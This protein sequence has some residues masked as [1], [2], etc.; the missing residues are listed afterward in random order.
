MAHTDMTELQDRIREMYIYDATE[1][2]LYNLE[3]LWPAPQLQRLHILRLEYDTKFMPRLE[4]LEF[5]LFLRHTPQAPNLQYLRLRDC[6]L[7]K[8][9]CPLTNLRELELIDCSGTADCLQQV[10]TSNSVT[11]LTMEH[12]IA[13]PSDIF[14]T[15]LDSISIEHLQK[16]DLHCSFGTYFY[17]AILPSLLDAK[18]FELNLSAEQLKSLLALFSSETHPLK[19]LELILISDSG[20]DLTLPKLEKLETLRLATNRLKYYPLSVLKHKALHK[21]SLELAPCPDPKIVADWQNLFD[22]EVEWNVTSFLKQHRYEYNL[23]V[24]T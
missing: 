20:M 7:D 17:E 10:L 15:H 16:L 2:N 18:F 6:N 1:W 9:T 24:I 22:S 13:A 12:W 3:F 21:F 14:V 8:P 19:C 4:L 23:R 11:S 5:P